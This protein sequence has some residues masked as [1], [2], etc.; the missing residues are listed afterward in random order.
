[1]SSPSLTMGPVSFSETPRDDRA[2]ALLTSSRYLGR[3]QRV[4]ASHAGEDGP[5][6][7]TDQ[8]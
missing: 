3:N 1:M 4:H 6:S 8:S 5:S 2:I 7:G